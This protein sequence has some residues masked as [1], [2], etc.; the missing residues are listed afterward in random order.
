[1]RWTPFRFNWRNSALHNDSF[2]SDDTTVKLIRTIRVAAIAHRYL[3]MTFLGLLLSMGSLARIPPQPRITISMCKRMM[4]CA[5]AA[6]LIAC[7][8]N[9]YE[10]HS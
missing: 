3:S 2:F 5:E 4:C 9:N 8:D 1:M 7:F 10:Y 6:V